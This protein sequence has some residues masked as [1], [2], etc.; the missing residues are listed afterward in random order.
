MA[1]TTELLSI[2]ENDTL[3]KIKVCCDVQVKKNT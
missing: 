3:K 2:Y 1:E